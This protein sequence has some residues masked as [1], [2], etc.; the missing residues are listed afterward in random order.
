MAF[1]VALMPLHAIAA[2]AAP[3]V[4]AAP[5]APAA[6]PNNAKAAAVMDVQSGRLLYSKNG[7]KPL[8]IASLTKIMTAIVAIEYGTLSDPVTVSSRAFGK[9]GSS[10]YLKLGQQMSLNDMLYGLMLRSGNDAATAIA[11][12]VGG[13]LDGF[14]YM[15]NREA[16][17]I[18]MTNSHFDNPHGLDSKTHYASAGD[19]AKLSAY[20]LRNPTFREIVK[21][22]VKRVP[23]DSGRGDYVW[24][25]K[26]KMLALFEG[27]D[28]VK[29]GY[30]K[31]AKRCLVSSAT[32]DGR[33]V[34][35]VTIDDG[36]DWA[37]HARLLQYG[38]DQYK[39]R[40]LVSR[41]DSVAAGFVAAQ[42][43][44]YPLTEAE[45]AHVGRTFEAEAPE[46][47]NARLGISGKLHLFVNEQEVGSVPVVPEGSA[48]LTLP[49]KSAF[50]PSLAAQADSGG[51]FGHTVLAL[52]KQLFRMGR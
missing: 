27:A 25:N 41:G 45:A 19:M 50:Q 2:P 37:D 36:S 10:I 43:F 35:V 26:N 1:V 48:R 15:M 42:S 20:A 31:T 21:T 44:T 47:A 39:N 8:P 33:Q 14:V 51:R 32:R 38:F 28:G 22:Q 46:S 16:E 6:P 9:E 11:E 12:H 5:A 3:A 34:V 13:S 17:A 7:D 30:T 4:P 23:G 29:T 24:Y 49:A 52:V 18:G 40:T